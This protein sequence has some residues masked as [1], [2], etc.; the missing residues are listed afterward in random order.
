MLGKCS[1]TE[2]NHHP[3]P[4]ISDKILKVKWQK[5]KRKRK[6]GNE[7]SINYT[8][9]FKGSILKIV[10]ISLVFFPCVDFMST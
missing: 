9:D 6:A 10:G 7:I 8:K 1:D 4:V 2:L 3:R 5:T